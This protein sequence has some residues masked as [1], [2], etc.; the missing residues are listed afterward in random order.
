MCVRQT[1]PSQ[2]LFWVLFKTELKDDTKFGSS[3]NPRDFA[4]VIKQSEA[5]MPEE[6][7]DSI[8]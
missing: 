2:E 3:K 8:S 5:K 6:V 4:Q 7:A 1:V